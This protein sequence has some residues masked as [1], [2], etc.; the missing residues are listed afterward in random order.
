[1][2][3]TNSSLVSY[4]N[5]SP[6]KNT[7][8]NHV[9]D[10]ISIH[11]YVGQASVESMG[12]YFAKPSVMASS[13]YGIGTDGRI[14]LFVEEKDRSW[15]TSSESND[16]RAVTIECAS[17]RTHP[18]AVNDKVFDSLIKL[19]ADICKRNDIK[20]LKWQGDKS[21]IGQVDKQ[22]MTVHRWF[23]NK[24]CP[25]QYLYDKHGEIAAA[26]NAILNPTVAKTA[27]YRVQVGAYTKKT[28]A[29]AMLA[30]VKKAGFDTY[31]AQIDGMYK[32]QVGAYSNKANADAML[33][34]VKGAGFTAF[35]TTQGGTGAPSSAQDKKTTSSTAASKPSTST[36][37]KPSTST[38]SKPTTAAKP[39]SKPAATQTK[40]T[41]KQVAE[42]IVKGQGNWGTGQTRINNLKAKGYNPTEVQNIVNQI[43]SGKKPTTAA[44]PKKTA[45]QVAKEIVKGVGGWGNGNTRKQRLKAAGYNPDE[46]QKIV[47]KLLG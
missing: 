20:E 14:G 28:N 23:K 19:V 8:R 35:I 16:N 31:L 5:I 42:Q 25:G 12:S 26:V 47:N 3:Y 7:P 11:V 40:L 29:D 41:A 17:D 15:C 10:T 37:A 45:T 1:M 36:T 39:A 21:L 18:Y 13:N 4:T 32:I 33:V 6:N 43:M 24:A 9:I 44:S 46:V 34:R 27:L 38:A 2:S 30:K 22:N